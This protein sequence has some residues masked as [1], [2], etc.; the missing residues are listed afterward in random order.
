MIKIFINLQE[1]R[2]SEPLTPSSDISAPS[3]PFGASISVSSQGLVFKTE[4]DNKIKSPEV[5]IRT[6]PIKE[7]A[8]LVVLPLNLKGN[9]FFY[10]LC[11]SNYLTKYRIF[12]Y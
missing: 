12:C 11:K 8:P 6:S 3:S 5:S 1:K 2:S 7:T 4:S 9:N 10:F